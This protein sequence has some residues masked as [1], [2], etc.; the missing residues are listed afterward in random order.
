MKSAIKSYQHL[1]A[2]G[3]ARE[4]AR[5]VLP[6]SIYTVFVGTVDLHNLAHFVRLRAAPDAQWEM[7]QYARALWGMASKIAPIACAALIP[8]ENL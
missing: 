1:L 2:Q 7:Q 8:P 4:Q 6:Q 3:V 5:M